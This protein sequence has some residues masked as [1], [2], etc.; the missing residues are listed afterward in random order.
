MSARGVIRAE[1]DEE[2]LNKQFVVFEPSW[3]VVWGVQEWLK[4]VEGHPF[5]EG[6]GMVDLSIL[7]MERFQSGPEI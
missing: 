7:H 4:V 2:L 3:L 1:I 5:K 6:H